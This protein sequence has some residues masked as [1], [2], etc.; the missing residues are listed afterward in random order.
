MENGTLERLA[1]R[2]PAWARGWP[3]RRILALAVVVVLVV[4]VA[5][6]CAGGSSGQAGVP[7]VEGSADA[8]VTGVRA[9]SDRTGGTLRPAD[10][11]ATLT[12]GHSRYV[13]KSSIGP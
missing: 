13:G 7:V 1:E 3:R 6:S 8:G 10:S 12:A 11:S 4:V 5:V 2:L 9:P